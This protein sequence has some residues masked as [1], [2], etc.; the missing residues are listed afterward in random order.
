MTAPTPYLH[1]PGTAREALTFYAGV[2]GGSA[3]L[4]TLADFQR[5]D[6]PA[7]AIAHGEL[8]DGPVALAASDATGDDEP[9]AARGLMLSLL[10]TTEPA[11]LRTWFDR[12]A[13]GG[14]VLDDLQP[15]PWGASDGQV[16]DRFGLRWLIGFEGDEG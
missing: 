4:F 9:F 5:S 6:G 8:V 2:F 3:R 1:L 12:L 13:D 11:T 7:D 14:E 10:G 16:V 15:R